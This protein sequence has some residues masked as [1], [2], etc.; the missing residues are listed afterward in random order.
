[1]SP[2]ETAPESLDDL[3]AEVLA[4]P[5]ARAAYERTSIERVLQRHPDPAARAAALCEL[6]V[7]EPGFSWTVPRTLFR[8]HDVDHRLVA[9]DDLALLDGSRPDRV[10]LLVEFNRVLD[11]RVG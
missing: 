6:L 3:V 4:D 5:V 8:L 1:M 10:N 9:R 11:A 7:D 2:R